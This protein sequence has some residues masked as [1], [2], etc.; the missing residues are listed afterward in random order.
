[1]K[2]DA[3][4]LMEYIGQ[5]GDDLVLESE[6]AI[7]AGARGR[8]PGARW[9]PMA[10]VLVLGVVIAGLYF[11]LPMGIMETGRLDNY[12]PTPVTAPAPAAAPLP[13]GAF[14]IPD[15]PLVAGEGE[16]LYAWGGGAREGAP[17]LF[18]GGEEGDFVMEFMLPAPAAPRRAYHP[19][20][21]PMLERV[22]PYA[23]GEQI[24]SMHEFESRRLSR[25][26]GDTLEVVTWAQTLPVYRRTPHF[27]SG[28]R[29]VPKDS[30]SAEEIVARIAALAEPLGYSIDDA[31]EI[32]IL[33]EQAFYFC[34]CCGAFSGEEPFAV[35]PMELTVRWGDR[36]I[37]FAEFAGPWIFM[38]DIDTLAPRM[39]S[40]FMEFAL[41][42]TRREGDFTTLYRIDSDAF[43]VFIGDYP[44]LTPAEAQERLLD[45]RHFTTVHDHTPTAESI[46]HVEITYVTAQQR[47]FMPF[48][49]F[50]VQ[51]P[52]DWPF[53]WREA[54]ES[55]YGVYYV[56]AVREEFFFGY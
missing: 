29:L 2:I 18:G 11:L 43:R 13:E 5:V 42:S 9:M 50:Y 40:W 37:T 51:M 48:F 27:T 55:I 47:I 45:G 52:P 38:H 28:Q 15:A 23:Q 44:I 56:A 20:G 30:P 32:N 49:R 14:T 4:K 3:E 12:M 31:D 25:A 7:P 36:G 6:T 39:D 33:Q 19:S 34:F 10:A 17:G 46:A 41:R 22:F 1:M 53:P 54:G 16:E 35:L 26:A 24:I 21:L 8:T